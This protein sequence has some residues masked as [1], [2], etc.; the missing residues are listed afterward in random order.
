M[1]ENRMKDAGICYPAYVTIL[2]LFTK[3]LS[4]YSH[5][6]PPL[7][8][9]DGRKIGQRLDPAASYLNATR[10]LPDGYLRERW[11]KDYSGI[12]Q[13]LVRDWKRWEGDGR[14]K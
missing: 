11:D 4:H 1:E 5:K 13:R 6:K 10:R 7:P 8:G 9:R 14:R 12:G 2:N 3:R